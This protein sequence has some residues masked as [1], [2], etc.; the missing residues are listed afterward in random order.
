MKIINLF[1]IQ[2][3]FLTFFNSVKADIKNRE[4]LMEIFVG[5]IEEG[6]QDVQIGDQFEYCACFTKE[7]SLGMDL[8]DVVLLGLDIMEAKNEKEEEQILISNQKVKSYITQC[9]IKLYE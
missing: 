8:K 6:N 7:V 5:C 2:I 4:A 9:A 1:L 3:I